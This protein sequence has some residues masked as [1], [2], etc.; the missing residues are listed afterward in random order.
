M[1]NLNYCE[2]LSSNK[3]IQFSFEWRYNLSFTDT[4]NLKLLLLIK[5]FHIL[6]KKKKHL[7]HWEQL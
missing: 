6:I 2:C 7:Q 4:C 3:L 1:R 5:Y